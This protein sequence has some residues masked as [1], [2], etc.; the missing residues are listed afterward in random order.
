MKIHIIIEIEID[1]KCS[2]KEV[3][4]CF[5]ENFDPGRK[6]SPMENDD[7]YQIWIKGWEIR[8]PERNYLDGPYFSPDGGRFEMKDNKAYFPNGEVVDLSN[9]DI[10]MRMMPLTKETMAE[11]RSVP[12]PQDQ[13]YGAMCKGY[14]TKEEY[15]KIMS[16]NR[17]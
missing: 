11:E 9:P 16:D 5:A 4:D 17:L 14:I 7:D 10:E 13:A 6:I 15:E 8:L 2:K 1:G 3:M 12:I